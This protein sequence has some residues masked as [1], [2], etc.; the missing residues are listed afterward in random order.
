VAEDARATRVRVDLLTCEVWRD[1]VAISLTP[2]EQ[3]VFA[4]L[5]R[6]V[7]RPQAPVVT[8]L[9]LAA[10]LWPEYRHQFEA[11]SRVDADLEDSIETAIYRLRGK[12]EP[13]PKRPRYIRNSRGEGYFLDLSES[14]VRQADSD[15]TSS[16]HLL[17][18]LWEIAHP[19]TRIW[20]Q[21]ADALR[22]LGV[23]PEAVNYTYRL[24]ARLTL[25]IEWDK[26]SHLLLLDEGPEGTVYCL[27][28]SWFAP[29]TRLEP[30]RTALP[31]PGARYDSFVLSGQQG[32]EFLLAII[33]TEPL[34]L[35]WMTDDPEQPAYAVTSADVDML[36]QILED[37]RPD[38][39]TALSSYFDVVV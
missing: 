7:D 21:S 26:P 11:R 20:P 34:A 22:G 17:G 1:G 4:T 10:Q 29:E 24:G 35:N 19:T 6:A 37:M 8:K 33:T 30:G 13:E 39:W 14:S 15:A 32:R 5:C 3:R 36:L 25:R 12:I 31:Q 28:P 16:A 18:G 9:E 2:Q 23:A 27:C 38:D